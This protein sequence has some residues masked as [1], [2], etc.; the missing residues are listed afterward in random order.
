[1]FFS[2]IVFLSLMFTSINVNARLFQQVSDFTSSFFRSMPQAYQIKMMLAFIIFFAITAGIN[3]SGSFRDNQK[4]KMPMIFSALLFSALLTVGIPNSFALLIAD[5]LGNVVGWIFLSLPLFFIILIFWLEKTLKT[6][7]FGGNT[8]EKAKLM[9]DIFI[10]TLLVILLNF[11]ATYAYNSNQLLSNSFSQGIL[12]T[13]GDILS[14]LM[15]VFIIKLA[16]LIFNLFGGITHFYN[17]SRQPFG[18]G[19]NNSLNSNN[20]ESEKDIVSDLKNEVVADRDISKAEKEEEKEEK[21][22]EKAE[23]ETADLIKLNLEEVKDLNTLKEATSKLEHLIRYLSNAD[24][25][26]NFNAEEKEIL[27]MVLNLSNEGIKITDKLLE[28]LRTQLKELNNE[29]TR[30]LEPFLK[31]EKFSEHKEYEA[32]QQMF[33]DKG[34][35]GNQLG[36]V[37]K[38]LNRI[39]EKIVKDSKELFALSRDMEK[40]IKN[41]S[42]ALVNDI[43]KILEHIAKTIVEF[44]KPRGLFSRL[45]KRELNRKAVETIRSFMDV[46]PELNRKL[47]LLEEEQKIIEENLK[48]MSEFLKDE[49]LQILKE[50]AIDKNI[51]RFLRQLEKNT[52]KKAKKTKGKKVK[53]SGEAIVE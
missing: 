11:S 21:M 1:M 50:I 3:L 24:N 19:P 13:Y 14:I 6:G 38:S 39:H 22:I 51:D 2:T 53:F 10:N 16:I 47:A 26:K 29:L 30:E 46:I 33:K 34:I 52:S 49:K 40:R 27:Q 12:M 20:V 18:L 45:R 41:E 25:W 36:S 42:A 4:A 7:I 15:I 43:K 44:I 48:R 17:M 37:T 32:I 35:K 5:M 23:E 28:E 9:V 8:D 31:L